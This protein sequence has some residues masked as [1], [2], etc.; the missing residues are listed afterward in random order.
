MWQVGAKKAHDGVSSSGQAAHG[1][2]GRRG[3]GESSTVCRGWMLGCPRLLRYGSHGKGMLGGLVGESP[4][5][6]HANL[7]FAGE[8]VVSAQSQKKKRKSKHCEHERTRSHL[9]ATGV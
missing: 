9:H 2:P 6:L 1:V 8:P 5:F 3:V 4:T 7:T